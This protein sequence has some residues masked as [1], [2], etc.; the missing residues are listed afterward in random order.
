VA[1]AANLTWSAPV[2]VENRP[3]FAIPVT[4][5]AIACPSNRFCL[6]AGGRGLAVSRDPAGPASAW[7]FTSLESVPGYSGGSVESMSCSSSGFCLASDLTELLYSRDPAGGAS[8]WHAAAAP[9][10]G[11]EQVVCLRGTFC[12]GITPA[13]LYETREPAGGA[14]AWHRI[15]KTPNA[16]ALACDGTAICVLFERTSRGVYVLRSARPMAGASSWHAVRLRVDRVNLYAAGASCASKSVCVLVDNDGN[17][18]TSSDPLGGSR[19]WRQF[20]IWSSGAIATPSISCPTSRLCVASGSF[21]VVVAKRPAAGRSAW[22]RSTVPASQSGGPVSCASVHL[23]VLADG[24]ILSTSHPA[25]SGGGWQAVNLGLGYTGL[26]A[27]DCPT[28]SL[29]F[30]AGQDSRLLSTTHPAG[31][32]GAWNQPGTEIATPGDLTSLSCDTSTFCAGTPFFPAEIVV[33]DLASASSQPWTV[34][35]RLGDGFQQSD[36]CPAEDLCVAGGFQGDVLTSTDP[37]AGPAAWTSTELNPPGPCSRGGCSYEPIG[38]I[39]CPASSFCAA[40]D[41]SHFWESSD[42]TGGRS[43][44]VSSKLPFSASLIDCPDASMCVVASNGEV[45][46]TSDPSTPDPT[47]ITQPLPTTPPTPVANGPA[48]PVDLRG[49]SCVSDQLCV[50]VDSSGGYAFSGDPAQAP[51]PWSA[52]QIDAPTRYA[53]TGPVSLTGVSCASDGVCVAIDGT[54]HVIVGDV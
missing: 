4:F 22:R 1:A 20:R 35:P 8:A 42:P 6:A 50:A 17:V 38:A 15:V 43:A 53:L 27:V 9:L 46:A 12:L 24:D 18:V 16:A 28:S 49:L 26:S 29:C 33:G 13:Y 36:D 51:E 48:L 3:P 5:S 40:T 44:W 21:G 19:H 2:L 7:S 10:G 23:C 54:G 14:G 31:G 47:W 25:R 41:G 39:S 37:T 45:A 11:L 30:A 52:T 34:G 32:A